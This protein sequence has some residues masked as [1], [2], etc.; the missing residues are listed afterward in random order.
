MNG[1]IAELTELVGSEHQQALAYSKQDNSIVER[2][3]KEVMKHLRAILLDRRMIALWSMDYLPL[4]QR[5]MNA[6]IHETIGVTP[7]ELLFGKAINLNRGMLS[8]FLPEEERVGN[9]ETTLSDYFGNMLKAQRT[10][11]ELAQEHQLTEDSFKL[12]G[13]DDPLLTFA[14]NSYVT[15]IPPAGG[16]QKLQFER[17]GPY[18]V[19]RINDDYT[20]TDLVNHKVITTHV[21]N[22]KAF[23]HVIEVHDPRKVA[24][25]NAGMFKVERIVAH[26]GSAKRR[27]EM[28]FKVKWLGYPEE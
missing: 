20:I 12:S 28:T 5:I 22:L 9:W 23:K 14:V 10:L 13:K 7:S 18:K 16:R 1:V 25:Q 4:V 8:P 19:T 21:T 24:A 17:A 6:Q 15:Y 26:R 3:N 11:I 27:T 2:A